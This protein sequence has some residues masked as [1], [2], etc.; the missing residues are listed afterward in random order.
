[1]V[2]DIDVTFSEAALGCSRII[3]TLEEKVNLKIP[4][5][6]QSGKVFKLKSKGLPALHSK[7]RGD[8]LV[9]V[10][11]R[12]PEKLGRQEKELLEKLA[13]LGL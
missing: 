13:S 2:C 4:N 7:N 11:V 10:H 9:C 6:T 8:L 12:T 1:L 3:Q 5:G